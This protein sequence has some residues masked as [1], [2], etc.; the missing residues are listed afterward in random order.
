MPDAV[1]DLKFYRDEAMRPVREAFEAEVLAWPGAS[2]KA[3][4]GCLVYFRGA[5]FFAFL[6]TDGL[7]LT[8][9]G[10]ADRATLFERPGA[11][12][13][14]M[15]GRTTSKWVQLPARAPKDLAP[16]FPYV[17]KSYDAIRGR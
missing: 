11:K 6:V 17:R 7:V 4:M 12:P 3:M 13:F 16:I 8:K 5:S 1:P 15:S 2:R 10:D 14:E 9:L